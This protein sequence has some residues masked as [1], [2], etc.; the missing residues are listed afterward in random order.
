MYSL[1]NINKAIEHG[2][3]NFVFYSLPFN[4][5]INAIRNPNI[6]FELRKL[7]LEVAYYFMLHYFYQLK[8]SI[9]SVHTRIGITRMINTIVGIDVVLERYTLFHFR[10]YRYSSA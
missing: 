6:S 5:M 1:G 10:S 2:D 8:D 7:N 4:L 9:S 3:W